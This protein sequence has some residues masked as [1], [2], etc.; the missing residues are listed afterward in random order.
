[1]AERTAAALVRL[2]EDHDALIDVHT[3][4][5]CIPFVLTDRVDDADFEARIEQWAAVISLPVIREMSDDA[6]ALQSLHRSWSAWAVNQRKPAF[7][8]ELSGFQRLEHDA[9]LRGGDSLLALIQAMELALPSDG[10][11][12]SA[13]PGSVRHRVRRAE[14]FADAPGLF[15]TIRVPGDAVQKGDL[16]G[17]IKSI[18]GETRQSVVASRRGDVLALQPVS[19]VHAGSWLVTLAVQE[20]ET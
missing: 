2:L 5:W 14:V 19:A 1:L 10:R 16:I 18:Q 12:A 6:A 20:S 15:E 17:W 13:R 8:L 9:A 4:G 11:A 3:A 7:T